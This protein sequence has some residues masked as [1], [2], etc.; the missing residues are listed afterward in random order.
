MLSCD[1]LF[2][3]PRTGACQAPLSMGVRD[4]EGLACQG[5]VGEVDASLSLQS[6]LDEI[7]KGP[8]REKAAYPDGWS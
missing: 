2:A 7:S 3:I 5:A 4:L 6:Q 8:W 1:R